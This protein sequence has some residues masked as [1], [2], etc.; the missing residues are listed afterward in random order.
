MFGVPKSPRV[1]KRIIALK[2]NH[3]SCRCG[4]V[5]YEADLDL[6]AGTI[7]CNCPICT[8]MRN[9][10]SSVKADAFRLIAGEEGLSDYQFMSRRA[11]HVFCKHCGIRAFM[12]ADVPGMGGARALIQLATLDDVSPEELVSGPV[13]YVDGGHDNFANPPAET[14]HL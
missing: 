12:R 10:G 4:A 13:R 9:W 6:A 3:G 2:T 11:H 1:I 7:K 8:K 14:R 5:R